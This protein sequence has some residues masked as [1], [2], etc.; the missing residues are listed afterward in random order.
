M[1]VGIVEGRI[2]VLDG[3]V[4]AVILT[5]N[6]IEGGTVDGEVGRLVDECSGPGIGTNIVYVPESTAEVDLSEIVGI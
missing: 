5:V 2:W 3:Q 1:I 4:L 6:M